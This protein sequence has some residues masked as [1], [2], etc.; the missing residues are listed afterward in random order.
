MNGDHARVVFAYLGRPAQAQR[1]VQP[2]GD[3][4]QS[5]TVVD[6]D[7]QR[8]VEDA[9]GIEDVVDLFVLEQPVGVDARAGDVEAGAGKGVVGGKRRPEFITEVGGGPGDRGGVDAGRITGQPEIVD[10]ER[11]ERWIA[12]PLAKPE[13]RAVR[14][15]TAVEPGGHGVDLAPVKVVVAVPLEVRRVDPQGAREEMHEPRHAAWE[16]CFRPWQTES[17][18]V[19]EP[20]FHRDSGL[21]SQL[22][23]P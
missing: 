2:V 18:R 19:A 13:Q 7:P 4:R 1:R 12:G 9:S 3:P 16:R 10:D 8:P 23:Q 15:G 17:H 21:T 22:L 6:G 14:G 5:R 11:F 20:E